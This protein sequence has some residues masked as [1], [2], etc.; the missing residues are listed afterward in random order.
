MYTNKIN[1]YYRLIIFKRCYEL[2]VL[3][4]TVCVIAL[5][6][7]YSLNYSSVLKIFK[8]CAYLS[9]KHNIL[10]IYVVGIVAYKPYKFPTT[11]ETET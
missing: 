2:N 7:M 3:K 5:C 9:V 4:K 10:F 6:C 11:F 8:T 1:K